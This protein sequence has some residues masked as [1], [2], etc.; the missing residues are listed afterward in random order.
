MLYHRNPRRF[1]N[2]RAFVSL[3]IIILVAPI[4]S[5]A[6]CPTSTVSVE[7]TSGGE[8]VFYEQKTSEDPTNSVSFGSCSA[9]YDLVEGTLDAVVYVY[10]ANDHYSRAIAVDRF[11]LH[12]VPSAVFKVR[13][14]L[15]L[16]WQ[17]DP[18]SRMAWA[19]GWADLTV[20]SETVHESSYYMGIA[21]YIELEV[22]AVE[23]EPFEITYE[24]TAWGK[25]YYPIAMMSCRL[26]FIGLPPGAEITSC[27]GYGSVIVPAEH[28]TWGRV[29]ALY[30]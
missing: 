3:F 26:E 5:G 22:A 8:V 13:L 10:E 30:R 18:S 6:Q 24:T 27:N 1:L 16:F 12:N 7:G 15:S 11:E 9:S 4:L 19:G 23:G 21:S 14:Y 17:A 2:F 25:G 20:G 29:K 28:T